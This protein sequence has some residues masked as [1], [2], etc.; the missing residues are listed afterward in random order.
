MPGPAGDHPDPQERLR[1]GVQQG[2]F[3]VILAIDY[4]RPR[5][6]L[7]VFCLLIVINSVMITLGELCTFV[8]Q[9]ERAAIPSLLLLRPGHGLWQVHTQ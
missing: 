2:R 8:E 7:N 5:V 4:G 3:K 9:G 1:H 6:N